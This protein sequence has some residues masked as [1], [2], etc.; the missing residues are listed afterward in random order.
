MTMQDI[1]ENWV[2]LAAAVIIILAAIVGML[3]WAGFS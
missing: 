1:K 2:L 3:Y